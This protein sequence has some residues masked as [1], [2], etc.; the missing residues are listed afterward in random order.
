M[1]P[2]AAER[3]ALFKTFGRAWFKQDLDLMF[4][5]A[6]PD[7]V[8]QSPPGTGETAPRRAQGRDQIAAE[9]ARRRGQAEGVRFHDVVYH[10]AEDASFMTFRMTG[11][12]VATGQPFETEGVERYTFR[13]GKLAVKDV[14]T[15]PA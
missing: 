15:K 6:T 1:T 4:Q 7:F 11:T 10:H 13:D 2:T 9:F 3:D 12:L 8:W 5:V 14:Y